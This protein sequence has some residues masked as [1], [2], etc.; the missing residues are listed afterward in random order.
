M[1]Y[2]SCCSAAEGIVKVYQAYVST[3]NA[4]MGSAPPSCA[5][6]LT[7]AAYVHNSAG[8]HSF[9][10]VCGDAFYQG[11]NIIDRGWTADSGYELLLSNPNGDAFIRPTA[12][13]GTL[14]PCESATAVSG[15]WV[16][17]GDLYAPR[18]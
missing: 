6:G 9:E 1:N 2:A 14:G 10:T 16:S 5:N 7:A 17:S 15:V 8:S 12:F 4:G 13:E 11:L 18:D 3:Y